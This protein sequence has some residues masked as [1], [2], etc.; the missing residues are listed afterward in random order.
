MLKAEIETRHVI[1]S[2][3]QNSQHSPIPGSAAISRRRSTST[4]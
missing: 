4:H 2:G 3:R 1:S